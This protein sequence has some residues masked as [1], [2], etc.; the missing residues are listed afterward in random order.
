[1]EFQN[2]PTVKLSDAAFN[3]KYKFDSSNERYIRKLFTD[4]VRRKRRIEKTLCAQ[5][6]KEYATLISFPLSLV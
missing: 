2:L 3:R 5:I 4:E 1:M 6:V